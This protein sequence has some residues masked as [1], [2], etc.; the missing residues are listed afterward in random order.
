MNTKRPGHRP[1]PLHKI[2]VAVARD[3]TDGVVAALVDAGFARERIKIVTA[4]DVPDLEQP[5]GGSGVHGFLTRLNLS[6][7]D[8][9]DQIGVA[10]RELIHGHVLVLV[11]IHDDAERH[12]A[13]TVLLQHGGHAMRYFGRWVITNLAGG[14]HESQ[15]PRQMRASATTGEIRVVVRWY[16]PK[17]GARATGSSGSRAR[18]AP[19]ITVARAANRWG[20]AGPAG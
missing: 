8:D 14:D 1:Y 9:L 15:R 16:W 18:A 13:Q 10:R 2:V 19:A 11:L 12:R 3:A 4:A 5:V 6:M 20:G 7:G 17:P